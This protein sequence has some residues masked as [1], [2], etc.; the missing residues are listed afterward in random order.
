MYAL[1]MGYT[2]AEV[3]NK[4]GYASELT[5]VIYMNNNREKVKEKANML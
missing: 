1:F 5:M 4:V 2:M 3:I